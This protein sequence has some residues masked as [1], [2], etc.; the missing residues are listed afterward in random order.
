MSNMSDLY[1]AN[2]LL[3]I[4]FRSMQALTALTHPVAW[5]SKAQPSETWRI[6]TLLTPS[7]VGKLGGIVL[8][9]YM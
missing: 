2:C 1:L 7:F 6:R 5:D 8:S 4:P 9:K 3:V